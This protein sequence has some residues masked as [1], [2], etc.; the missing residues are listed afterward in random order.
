MYSQFING[1]I[2]RLGNLERK[3]KVLIKITKKKWGWG[4]GEMINYLRHVVQ[5]LPCYQ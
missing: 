1:N 3:I 4:R 5:G 2:D